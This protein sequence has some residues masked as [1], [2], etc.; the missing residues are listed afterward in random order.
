VTQ[1]NRSALENALD[2]FVYAPVGLAVTA[3]EELPKLAEKGRAQV[4]GQI[5]IARMVGKFAVAQGRRQLEQRLGGNGRPATEAPASRPAGPAAAGRGEPRASGVT[6]NGT[7]ARTTP[8]AIDEER[9]PEAQEPPS[10][11]ELIDSD[12]G[13]GRLS[14][15]RDDIAEVSNMH[16][17]AASVA[18]AP[19]ASS[20]SA[21]QLAIPGYDS[22]SASQVVQ[23]LAGLSKDELEA[24]GAYESAHRARRTI[25]TRVNQLKA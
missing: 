3:L 6:S 14:G 13:Y 16:A 10:E 21:D 2:V 23:R 11:S 4:Q 25:L 24:V 17:G 12:G 19:R 7:A 5:T 15:R 22:L 20:P 9:F 8:P 18:P 1:D